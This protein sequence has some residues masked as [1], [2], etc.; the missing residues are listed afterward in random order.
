MSIE[1]LNDYRIIIFVSLLVFFLILEGVLADAHLKLKGLN[2]LKHNLSNLFISVCNT[3]L[4]KII[5]PFGLVGVC[6]Y[7]QNHGVG[8]FNLSI[9]SKFYFALNFFNI[10]TFIISILILD[11]C[12]YYQHKLFHKIPL[13]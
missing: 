4:L 5:F 3:L 12:I 8:L 9:L 1:L 2:R 7:A 11:F 10:L 6:V 13:L